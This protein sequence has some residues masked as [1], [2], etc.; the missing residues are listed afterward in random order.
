MKKKTE[1]IWNGLSAVVL[2]LLVLAQGWMMWYVWGLKMLPNVFFLAICGALLL[3]DA[4]LSLLLFRGKLGRWGRKIG[5]GKQIVGYLLSLLIIVLSL[6]GTG[7]AGKVLGTIHAITSPEKINVILE[8][9]V[10]SEDSARYLQDTADY[11]FA[12]S[13]DVP[14]ED[15]QKILTE[16]E[17]LLGTAADPVVYT[18]T[19]SLVDALLAGE[20]DAVILNSSY[21]A[22][23][24]DMGGYE[25][26]ASKIRILHELVIEKEVPKETKPQNAEDGDVTDGP[27]LVYISGNDA[28]RPEL[29]DGGS[30]VNILI[31]VNPQTHQVLMINTPRDYY[32]VNPASGNGS[33]DKLSHCGLRGIDNCVGAMRELY[34][35]EIEHYARINFSGFRTLVDAIGGVTVYSERS[36]TAGIFAIKEGENHL[37]GEQAL[38]F[39][40]ERKNLPGGDNDRGKNQMRLITGMINQLSAGNLI[41]NYAQILE[42]L[43]GMFATNF[44]AESIGKLVQLQL[45]E[46]PS[47]EVLTF[48][49]TGDNGN[50]MC[51]GVGGYGYV[52]YPHEHMVNH[53]AD[54]MERFLQGNVLTQEDM[55]PQT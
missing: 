19:A 22:V 49:V 39:A 50:D 8:I 35:Q 52:M 4:L 46:K 10:R 3:L 25:D 5:H 44:P 42:S 26:L 53:A 47:W 45:K 28:L 27:F 48:A 1:N 12:M 6:A 17:N 18:D 51:W 24:E 43:E 40:R 16:L 23:L 55:I 14:E 36:F 30:D 41:A 11:T 2:V 38:A 21:L 20:V 29:A 32:V 7:V 13:E 31:L 9:Y 34:G 33:R 15:T 54:L 37:N